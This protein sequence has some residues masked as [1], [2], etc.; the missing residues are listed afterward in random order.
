MATEPSFNDLEK[1][2]ITSLGHTILESPQAFKILT[3][4]TFLC[5]CR[6]YKDFVASCFSA[7]MPDL[8]IMSPLRMNN[9]QVSPSFKGGRDYNRM[10]RTIRRYARTHLSQKQGPLFE[11]NTDENLRDL[12]IDRLM[13]AW[14]QDS[15]FYWTPDDLSVIGDIGEPIDEEV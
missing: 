4:R 12:S 5:S 13:H 11:R 15:E 2:F 9:W 14:L 1:S 8:A 10:R 6:L 7:A 3:R